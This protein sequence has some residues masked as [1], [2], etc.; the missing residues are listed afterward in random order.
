ME[1]SLAVGAAARLAALFRPPSNG[2]KSHNVEPVA[3]ARFDEFLKQS[4][5]TAASVQSDADKEALVQ[6]IP[7][8]GKLSERAG[9]GSPRR[10]ALVMR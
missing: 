10:R 3:R 6:A 8:H 1:G 2:S 9:A 4:P 7:G 5:A